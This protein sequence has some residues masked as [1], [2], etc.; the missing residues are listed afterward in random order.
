LMSRAHLLVSTGSPEYEGL[1][2]VLL[3]AAALKLPIV[4]L[5]AG[6]EWLQASGAGYCAKGD[7]DA[8]I[9]AIQRGMS[10]TVSAEFQRYGDAGRCYIE[11]EHDDAVVSRRFVECLRTVL[12]KSSGK[13][14]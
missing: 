10:H 11:T 12:T 6:A 4:S 7:R 5:E 3:Q 1:P 14:P 9:A 2:N 13:M 8:F